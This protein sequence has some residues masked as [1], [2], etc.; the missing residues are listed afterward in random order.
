MQPKIIPDEVW[1]HAVELARD[2][3]NYG[4][5]AKRVGLAEATVRRDIA[6]REARAA[7][8][9]KAHPVQSVRHLD[10]TAA[11]GIESALQAIAEID[12]LLRR[13]HNLYTLSPAHRRRLIRILNTHIERLEK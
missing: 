10:R 13:I 11:C 3:L 5:I 7:A 1:A 12:T 8:D 4:Q 2:G 6:V 9:P